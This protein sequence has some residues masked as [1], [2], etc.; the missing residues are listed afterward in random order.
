[1]G[2]TETIK[3][4]AIYV[5]LPSHEM[6]QRWK[7]LARRQGTSISKFVIEHVESS[8]KEEEGLRSDFKAR[9]ELLRRIQGLEEENSKLKKEVNVLKLAM[10]RLEEELRGYRAKPFLEEGF[11]GLRGFERKLVEMLRTRGSIRGEDLF[12]LLD[13]DPRDRELTTSVYRQL[14]LLEAYGL[15]EALPDGW[16]WK[17]R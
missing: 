6:V 2:K 8:L 17:K 14:K 11:S 12:D 3:E 7:K 4:R 5:Y 15:V 9:S 13:I 1:M 16:R 10:E